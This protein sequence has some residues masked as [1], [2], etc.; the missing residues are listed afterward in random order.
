MWVKCKLSNSLINKII[1]IF[2]RNTLDSCEIV[3]VLTHS[4]I[5]KNRVCLWAITNH[6]LNLV[7]VFLYV[8]RSEFDFA[9]CCFNFTRE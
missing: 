7:E 8:I 5:V 6:F 3:N 9:T 4:H 2:D 1:S